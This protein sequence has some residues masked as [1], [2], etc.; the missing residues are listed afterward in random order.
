MRIL[1]IKDYFEFLFPILATTWAV[2]VLASSMGLIKKESKFG[3]A[4]VILFS[5]IVAVY[6]FGRLSLAEYLLSLNSN[7]SIGSIALLIIVMSKQFS[8]KTFL[9]DTDFQQ[10]L[11]W[12]IIVSLLLYISYLGFV[13][14][15]LY[16]MGYRFS[17]LFIL[18]AVLTVVLYL[19]RNPLAY[20]F[21]SYILAFDLRLLHSDNFF[22]YITDGVLFFLS[23]AIL[24]YSLVNNAMIKYIKNV[25]PV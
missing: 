2:F 17:S 4:V 22:D 6:P 10:F 18:I 23:A 5:I 25:E 19:L 11:I 21:I 14:F 15:D 8:W 24:L 13:S 12:N 16:P 20:I 7:Y 1:F 9:S 3:R